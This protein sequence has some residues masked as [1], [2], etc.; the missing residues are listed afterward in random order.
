MQSAALSPAAEQSKFYDLSLCHT[1]VLFLFFTMF[2][3]D[4][5]RTQLMQSNW[6]KNQVNSLQR[7]KLNA[8]GPEEEKYFF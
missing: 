2:W 4:M 7:D 5:W 6:V 3:C 1:N 8:L